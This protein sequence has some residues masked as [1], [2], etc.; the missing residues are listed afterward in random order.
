[1]SKVKKRKKF[2]SFKQRSER[3]SGQDSDLASAIRNLGLISTFNSCFDIEDLPSLAPQFKTKV[4]KALRV[5]FCEVPAE[6]AVIPD[7][8]V[9]IPDMYI[10]PNINGE[11]LSNLRFC[12]ATIA[13]LTDV[14]V[15]TFFKKLHKVVSNGQSFEKCW[16]KYWIWGNADLCRGSCKLK[17]TDQILWV[18]HVISTYVTF[19][20]VQIS[21]RAGFDLTEPNGRQSVLTALSKIWSSILHEND[22]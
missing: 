15:R 17:Y 21:A 8:E 14:K 18:V 10:Q 12:V 22:D 4:M 19:H 9:T 1:M 16:I 7:V 20:K 3:I 13:R 11:I 5:N 6:N 2:E